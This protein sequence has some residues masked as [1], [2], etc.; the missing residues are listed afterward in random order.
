MANRTIIAI[1]DGREQPLPSG[2]TPVDAGGNPL[3]STG[4]ANIVEDTT[5]Q[6]G[7]NLDVNG[8]SIA[9]ITPT[10]LGYLSGLSSA[11]Q[12][13]L[14]NKQASDSELTAIAGLTSAANKIIRFTGSGTAG[15]LDFVDED[16]MSSNSATAIPSQQSVKAYVDSIVASGVS[17]E[18]GYDASANSPDLDSSP[19]GVSKGDMYTVTT[20]GTFF[21]VSVE[22]GDVLIAEIDNASVE[23]D[24]TIVQTNL[25]ASSI[26]T[27]YES[28]SNTNAYTDTEKTKLAGIE[29]GADVTDA[30]NVAAAGAVMESDTTTASMSFVVDED[31]MTSNSATKVPTQQSVKAYADTKR[32]TVTYTQKFFLDGQN[33]LSSANIM[34]V[35]VPYAGYLVATSIKASSARTAGTLDAE[36]HKNGT[37]LTPTG[38]DLQLA[39]SPTTKD[40]AS[41]TYQTA[42]YDIA[43]GDTVGFLVTTSSWAPLANSITMT[44]TIEL[45]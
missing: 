32:K 8:F 11:L 41:V 14:D 2:D 16:N 1:I 22:V 3:S 10:E 40:N 36:P 24:W 5:P 29:S 37:G 20:A 7:G 6:L 31:A 28:N 38:L 4:L 21:T 19:S 26:K 15:L 45:S 12:T 30:T 33:Q 9:G 42:S 27:L 44:I 39:A 34:D 23:A 35:T 13:Q 43:A 18:G 25:T 17:Y